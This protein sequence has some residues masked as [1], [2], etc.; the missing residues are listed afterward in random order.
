MCSVTRLYLIG[1]IIMKKYFTKYQSL[2][3]TENMKISSL[4]FHDWWHL[5]ICS[6]LSPVWPGKWSPLDF[7]WA[8]HWASEY[9][10]LDRLVAISPPDIDMAVRTHQYLG[11]IIREIKLI[12]ELI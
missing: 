4:Y 11:P 7:I 9:Q 2:S 12:I 8:E 3:S 10:T 1:L 5:V 6:L